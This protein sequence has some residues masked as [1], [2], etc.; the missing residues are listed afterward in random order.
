MTSDAGPGTLRAG[1][2]AVAWRETGQ[3]IVVLDLQGSVYFGLN[4]TA[5]RLWKLLVQGTSRDELSRRL[6]T[7]HGISRERA[8]A[9]VDAFLE[10]LDREGLLNAG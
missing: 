5:A 6:R 1:G 2:P 7:E 10:M 4:P 3:E 9:D 8:D